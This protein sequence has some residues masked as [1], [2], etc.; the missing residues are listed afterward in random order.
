MG[1]IQ[2]LEHSDRARGTLAY[3]VYWRGRLIESV[4]EENLIVDN[5]KTMMSHLVAGDTTN[6]TIT[7]IGFGSDGTSPIASNTT[8]T[9]LYARTIGAASYPTSSS[10]QFAWELQSTEANG[11]SIREFALLSANNG[12]FARRTRATAIV[13]TSDISLTGTWGISF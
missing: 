9:D 3:N 11:L 5:M 2:L 8:L 6:R 7:K 13:K 1:L 4:R 10:V 12:M